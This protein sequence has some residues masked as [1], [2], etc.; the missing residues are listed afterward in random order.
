VTL[1]EKFQ[2]SKFVT[3]ISTMMSVEVISL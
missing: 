3:W 2:V 1:R